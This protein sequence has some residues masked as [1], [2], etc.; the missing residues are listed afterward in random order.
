ME[1]SLSCHYQTPNPLVINR[2]WVGSGTS[3][4]TRP[5]RW[6][7]H[8]GGLVLVPLTL[9]FPEGTQRG[10][11]V[12]STMWCPSLTHCWLELEPLSLTL[13]MGGEI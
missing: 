2:L 8:R 11:L 13:L 3:V 9:P 7:S 6:G 4:S 10:D 5:N 1:P 12:V